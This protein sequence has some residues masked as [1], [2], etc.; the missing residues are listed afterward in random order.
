MSADSNDTQL[1]TGALLWVIAVGL[2]LAAVYFL[3]PALAS[4]R[5]QAREAVCKH[6]LKSIGLASSMYQND[7]DGEWPFSPDGSL[8]SLSLLFNQ[9]VSPHRYFVCPSTSD[10]APGDLLVA[11]D[12]TPVHRRKSHIIF[13]REGRNVLFSSGY[14]A[15]VLEDDFQPQLQRDIGRYAHYHEQRLRKR[16]NRQL[17]RP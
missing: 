14:A 1:R 12:K 8:A 7:H 3:L 11:Y 4:A 15:F 2:A 13:S 16:P 6:C 10:D 9:Y 5:D 17:P